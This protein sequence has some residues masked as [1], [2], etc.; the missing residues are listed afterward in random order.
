LQAL[1]EAAEAEGGAAVAACVAAAVAAAVLAAEAVSLLGL[2]EQLPPEQLPPEQLPQ[3][4]LEL[5]QH[6]E[7]PSPQQQQQP[8]QGRPELAGCCGL[9]S[10]PS[11]RPATPGQEPEPL[12]PGT[13][14]STAAPTPAASTPTSPRAAAVQEQGREGQGQGLAA[15]PGSRTSRNGAAAGRAEAAAST[16]YGGGLLPISHP[17]SLDTSSVASAAASLQQSG[18][19]R[20]ASRA[21]SPVWT[22]PAVGRPAVGGPPSSA[23]SSSGSTPWR[24]PASAGGA[25]AALPGAAIMASPLV[26]QPWLGYGASPPGP[27]AAGAS[28]GSSSAG[29][30]AAA[31]SPAAAA[32]ASAGKVAR[33]TQKVLDGAARVQGLLQDAPP[34]QAQGDAGPADMSQ[35]VAV[36][37]TLHDTLRST[38][39]AAGQLER[40]L[41]MHASQHQELPPEQSIGLLGQAESVGTQ[42]QAGAV[43]VRE[44]R[45]SLAAAASREELLQSLVLKGQQQAK[46][47]ML[48]SAAQGSQLSKQRE[49]LQAAEQALGEMAGLLAALQAEN[50]NLRRQ[51]GGMAVPSP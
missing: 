45:A 19:G 43:Q 24:S 38:P 15:T 37:Q 48:H 6:Q 41:H 40:D 17:I 25:A 16:L 13:G 49:A 1:E 46:G 47:L 3:E 4:Q 34:P 30:A 50:S 26:Q 39:A 21:D 12:L 29:S 14:P 10:R 7:D 36:A 8:W 28:S 42:L 35:L 5:E 44:L 51:L 11:T 23:C 2:Q 27:C 33:S 31:A 9:S 18:D 20:L 22:E 32:A